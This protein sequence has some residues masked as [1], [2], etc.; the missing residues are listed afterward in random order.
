MEKIAVIVGMAIVT[1]IPRVLPL[2]KPLKREPVF[3]KYIPVAVFSSLVFPELLLSDQGTLTFD[4]ET[5]AGIAAFIVAW[6]TRN[7][8]VTMIAAI[9]V[10]Y[11]LT[12]L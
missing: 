4:S 6:K 12:T 3:L 7:L 9:A 10:L 1:F 2:L 11:V 8:L 5:L